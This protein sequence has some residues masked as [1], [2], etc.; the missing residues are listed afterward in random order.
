[1]SSWW[2][3]VPQ[4]TTTSVYVPRVSPISL[5]PLCKALQNQKVDLTQDP[6]KL[7]VCEILCLPFKSGVSFSYSLPTPPNL[8][9]TDLKARGSGGSSC[10]HRTHRLGSPICALDSSFLEI[11]QMQLSSYLR[12][13][14]LRM[15]VLTIPH[16]HTSHQSCC[17][18]FIIP[19]VVDDVLT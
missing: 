18:S 13:T 15:C 2:N 19:L 1:M 3:E 10:Q 7:C 4:M 11:L 5:L 12:V 17:G 16:L 6:L 8:S 9:L 14:H